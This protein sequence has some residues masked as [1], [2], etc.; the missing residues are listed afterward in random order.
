VYKNEYIVES[1]LVHN[2]PILLAAGN[3]S[4]AIAVLATLAMPVENNSP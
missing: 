1:K 2:R 3:A 4:D